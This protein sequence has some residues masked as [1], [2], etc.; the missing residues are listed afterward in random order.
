MK[1]RM[2]WMSEDLAAAASPRGALSDLRAYLKRRQRHQIVFFAAAI[3]LTFLMLYGF[4]LEMKAKPREYHR[5]IIYFKQWNTD[6]SDAEIVAQ[7]KIDGPEQTKR[8]EAEK[9]L[10][11]EKRAIFKRLGDQMN[12]VGLY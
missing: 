6:R 9:R 12:S 7:Q 1:F 11:A 4:F 2:P 5:D 8:E 10:E 3:G